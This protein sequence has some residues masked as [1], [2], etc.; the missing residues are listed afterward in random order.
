MENGGVINKLGTYQVGPGI[1]M[2][3]RLLCVAGHAS[4]ASEVA[5]Q[6]C[7]KPGALSAQLPRLPCRCRHER[8]RPAAGGHRCK[9]ALGACVRGGRELQVCAV[10]GD[11][12]MGL[13]RGCCSLGHS[14]GGR[15]CIQGRR[16]CSA[17][18]L[19]ECASTP[20]WVGLRSLTLLVPCLPGSRAHVCHAS[21]PASRLYPL[22]Q[23]DMPLER[24]QLDFGPLLPANVAID[25]P[26]RDYTPPQVGSGG[27]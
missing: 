20:L 4:W 10:S 18:N 1:W 13:G 26:S 16:L 6:A 15:P 19:Q 8:C 12:Q 22:N 25:N 24:K 17:L 14:G 27:A 3:R 2:E 5:N 21:L 23:R 7:S 9:G 11:G